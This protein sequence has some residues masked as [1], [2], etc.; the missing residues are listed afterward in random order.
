MSIEGLQIYKV[1][2]LINSNKTK[3]I[4]VFYGEKV[5]SLD[6]NKE[7]KNILKNNEAEEFVDP[8][9]KNVIFNHKE[10]KDIKD[11]NI[12]VIFSTQQ[13][14]F[15]DQIGVLKIKILTEFKKS[16]STEEIYL[17]CQKEEMLNS[18][19]IFESLTQNGRLALNKTRLLQFLDNILDVNG[20]KHKFNLPDKE[21][22]DYSD[23]LN[24]NINNKIFLMNKVLGQKFFIVTNEYPFIC[25]PFEVSQY[26]SFIEKAS[27]KSLSTLNSHLLLNTGPIKNNNIY[28]C[29]ADDVLK[30]EINK[31]DE[32]MEQYTIKIYYPRLYAKN[33]NSLPQ[34]IQERAALI[35]ENDK[36]LS[37]GTYETFESVD[38]FYDIYKYKKSNLNY[39]TNGIKNINF[40][41][42]PEYKI[43]IPLDVIFR[44]IHATE[45]NPLIKY[46]QSARQEKVYRLYTDKFAKDGKKI[47]ALP[48]TTINKLMKAIGKTKSVAVHIN[49]KFEDEVYLIDCEFEED[50]KININTDFNRTLNTDE[51]DNLIINAVNP[52]IDEVKNYLEQN[53]YSM[54]LFTSL[55]N[56]NIEINSLSYESEIVLDKISKFNLKDMRGCLSSVFL[57]ETDKLTTAKE[58]LTLR[59]KR[60][61][62]Y[63]KTTSQEAFILENQKKYPG[64]VLIELLMQNYPELKK[65]EAISLIARLAT[66]LE[67]ERGARKKEMKIKINPG[68]RVNIR[69]KPFTNN[70]IITV[71]NINDIFYLD[72]IPIYLD[73][74]IRLTQDKSS[75]SYPAKRIKSICSG[76]EKDDIVIE[77]IVSVSEAS[78][79]DQTEMPYIENDDIEYKQIEA[80]E[81]SD[82]GREKVRNAISMF[83]GDGDEE[84][85]EEED[86]R[87][88][89]N[90]SSSEDEESSEKSLS[91]FGDVEIIKKP[92]SSEDEDE[93]SSEKS[94]SSF[95]DVEI[96][97][98]PVS[99]E[100]EGSEIII[101]E[102][103]KKESEKSVEDEESPEEIILKQKGKK[104]FGEINIEGMPISGHNSYFQN[105]I[106]KRDPALILKTD[107]GKYRRYSRSCL[108]SARR[109]PVILN[110]EELEKIKKQHPGFLKEEDVVNYGSKPDKD[111][112]YICPKYWDMKRETIVTDEEIKKNN[113]EDK[114]ISKGE[115]VVPKG[116]Y[117]YKFLDE[118]QYPNF[119]KGDKHPD[120]F[121]LPCCVSNFDTPT[122]IST[123]EK[124]V[125]KIKKEEKGV[126][127]KGE[128]KGKE[129]EKEKEIETIKKEEEKQGKD[130]VIGPEK[131]PLTKDRWGYLPTPVQK[132]LHEINADCQISKV[133]TNLKPNHACL[134]RHGVESSPTQSFIGC[135]ADAV[136]FTRKDENGNPIRVSIEKMKEIII[137][138]LNIDKFIK[139]QNGNLVNDFSSPDKKASI[140]KYK[141]SKLYSKLKNNM[142]E[143]NTKYLQQVCD[144]FEN[145]I[146]FL[147]DKTAKI[148]YTYLWDI[149]CD[150]N[151]S[152]FKTG[153]NLVIFEIPNNDITNNVDLICPTN[154]YST[155]NYDSRRPTL[156][157]LKQEEYYEPIYSYKFD[158]L[159]NT[160][161]ITKIFS[162][163][164][165]QLSKSMRAVFKNIIKPFYEDIN[166]NMNVT[167]KPKNSLSKKVYTAEH[168]MLLSKI[169]QI[170]NKKGYNIVKQV[171]NYQSKVIGIIAESPSTKE[172]K[173]I[174]GFIPCYP[175][176]ID[177][178]YNY[179]FMI[180]PNLWENYTNTITFLS[181]LSKTTKGAI[182]CNPIFKVI[183]DEMV[184]GVLTET[185]QFV[186]LSEPYPVSNV[187]DSIPELRDNNYIINK[188][189]KPM[190]QSDIKIQ[191]TDTIDK[192]R[193]NYI[194]KIKLETN[195]F[196]VFRSTIRIL[197]NDYINADIRDEIE[198]EMNNNYSIYSSKLAKIDSL[199][200]DLV[201]RTNSIKFIENTD[202][203]G[204]GYFE[205]TDTVNTCVVNETE[206]K[207]DAKAPFCKYV[208]DDKNRCQLLLPKTNLITPTSNNEVYYYARMADELV[209]YNR[210]KSF[211]LEP[212]FYLSFGNIGYNLR[213]NE[214]ILL[215][216]LL[217]E[218]FDN[219][220]EAEFNKYVKYNN[221]DNTEPLKT[222]L[223]ENQVD[224]NQN[225]YIEE[226]K[227]CNDPE[228]KPIKSA[229]LKNCFPKTYREV[230]YN[231]TAYCTYDFIIDIIKKTKKVSYTVSDIRNQLFAEYSKYYG[232]YD[233]KII[234]ILI[235]EG[236]KTMGDQVKAK[237]LSFS[238]FL[239][240]ENYFLTTF[241]YWLLIKAHKIPTIFVSKDANIFLTET[242]YK[243]NDFVGY[244]DVDDTFVVII[245]PG[246]RA[247]NVPS[248]K[249]IQSPDQEIQFK[250]DDFKDCQTIKGVM[251]AFNDENRV[252][253]ENFLSSYKKIK[254]TNYVKKKPEERK[255]VDLIIVNDDSSSSVKSIKPLKIRRTRKP[256]RLIDT[257][258]TKKAKP[259]LIIESDSGK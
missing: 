182:K 148:D 197:L 89:K 11:N 215:E 169:I 80:Y 241:D 139:Y 175:S 156:I 122:V 16:I 205:L 10:L 109:Q 4:Y 237:T 72:T 145:F 141:S 108:S 186:Q 219:L 234:D 190:K 211:I 42:Y 79:K 210:I 246:L 140:E 63:N 257:R 137:N 212:Q 2:H 158:N 99:S 25:N 7:F 199:L 220:K 138:S 244:G 13:L 143:E 19:N 126:F 110:K 154:H 221:Y 194:N 105:R 168:P 227:T 134:L 217:N 48:R 224:V 46:N 178:T 250:L 164:D 40:T 167:C 161:Y 73:S 147:R 77:D 114:I 85:E 65:N 170:L 232:K 18:V 83:F 225:L 117:I 207:C 196:N 36:I 50:G 123:R 76:D 150:K 103:T 21:F 187:R 129:K 57:I 97:K 239:L 192:D 71:E 213:E 152:I 209:R 160:T 183:E 218:Y 193:E 191:M 163:L 107:I 84:E 41:I 128:E 240:S 95:G 96:I 121:C 162:E 106:E 201:K 242:G 43:K 9:T 1:H 113:L 28:L 180:E 115:K 62:N 174:S 231:N 78:I 228:I 100:D 74:L 68:F 49:Y 136:F 159:K 5:G 184:I 70:L 116:K 176:S 216:S 31:N 47:P 60:V 29:I 132:I 172:Q 133:N 253:I 98:K 229:K 54:D 111:F 255:K 94:L 258:K 233:Q 82:E 56:P 245:V 101:S 23:I 27:R 93:E 53:G 146:D 130:Y 131:Y 153:I 206:D 249:Y 247:E 149:V 177:E 259:Q 135:I 22:Y 64:E 44:L 142:T 75:T 127:K 17:F 88:G 86:I 165:P 92:V 66:E 248:Y 8:I 20:K 87:G 125:G 222:I 226:E 45:T 30:T 151:D 32:N 90:S 157:L 204:K 185:N 238:N 58:G 203:K 34:L 37:K 6:I 144:S 189:D 91:S 171:V 118:K 179:V 81:D 102:P 119:V 52:I 59:F 112:Y 38:L 243:R 254:K 198:T 155:E 256:Q 230:E 39:K 26:D 69:E 51:F 235:E 14:H 24:L 173:K 181:N 3:A 104:E 252:D 251:D 124:C 120:G 223:Y 15:D 61:A 202:K 35:H 166:D 200:R 188:N 214:I 33:I 55:E 208:R 67:L 12:N 195:F 236:K